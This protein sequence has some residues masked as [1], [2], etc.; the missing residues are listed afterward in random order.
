MRNRALHLTALLVTLA[1]LALPAASLAADA[2]TLKAKVEKAAEYLSQKGEAGLPEFSD[3][4]SKWAQ[5]P[6]IFVYDLKGNIIAH[7]ANPKLVGKNLM[8]LKD[9]KGNMFAAEFVAVAKD[10]GQGWVEYWWPK[11]G[12][13]KPMQKVSYIKRVPGQDMLVGAGLNNYSKAKAT[14]EAGK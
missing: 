10:P 8:G 2:K 11:K 1:L 3:T 14:A 13:N 12:S 4:S 9:V 7:G 6:Y 5:T